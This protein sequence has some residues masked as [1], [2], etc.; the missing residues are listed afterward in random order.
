MTLS[1]DVCA[2]VRKRF[3]TRAILTMISSAALSCCGILLP[4]NVK[5][6][7]ICSAP[8]GTCAPSTVIDDQAIAMI[9]AARPQRP[10]SQRAGS[11]RYLPARTQ[12]MTPAQSDAGF[13][14]H[15]DF[16]R[17]SDSLA[18]RDART[19]RVVFPAFIDEAGNLH[20]ARVVHAVADQG[21]WAQLSEGSLAPTIG[22]ADADSVTAD[23]APAPPALKATPGA[24]LHPV[25]EAPGRF[26]PMPA[27]A[28]PDAALTIEGIRAEVAE[29]LSGA[30]VPAQMPA[31]TTL[32]GA[33]PS[34][35]LE[36]HLTTRS[37]VPEE[38]A[39]PPD[40]LVVTNAPATFAGPEGE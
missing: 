13:A 9:A 20:E 1:P 36:P 37:S 40:P 38:G 16:A 5:G 10:A 14:R 23:L 3:L 12:G 24:T 28:H 26:V 30:R 34:V 18:H 25:Q 21:G 39:A 29:R 27:R 22:D 33:A 11:R 2:R 31:P 17:I 7:F 15:R 6:S 19:L 32:G 8:G 35:D 4:D